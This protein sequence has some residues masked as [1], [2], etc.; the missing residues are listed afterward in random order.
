MLDRTVA[1][2]LLNSVRNIK[3]GGSVVS[4]LTATP[5][6]KLKEK[7]MRNLR[8]LVAAAGLV[9]ALAVCA[10]A[11]ETN[12]PPC[13]PNPGEM[14]TPPCSAS[15]FADDS[16]APGEMNAP[17]SSL[18]AEASTVAISFFENLMSY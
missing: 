6:G 18:L 7:E 15:Q 4:S 8:K 14:S 10:F 5:I 11:G 9:L 16:V 3:R 2:G 1:H 17:P 12:A 13:D